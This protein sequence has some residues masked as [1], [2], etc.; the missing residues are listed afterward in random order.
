MGD[1]GGIA[2]C[3]EKFAQ[4]ALIIG[5]N[6][7]S[8]DPGREYRRATR[9]YGAAASLRAPLD[10]VIDL[11][12]QPVYENH[13]AMLR[14]EIGDTSFAAAWVEGQAMALDQAATYAMGK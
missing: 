11:V 8:V 4:I 14:D 7:S 10:S 2:W 12:D 13:L 3:L 5:G 1:K 9:L 6:E